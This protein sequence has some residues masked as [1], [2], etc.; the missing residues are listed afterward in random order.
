MKRIPLSVMMCILPAAVLGFW[1][2]VQGAAQQHE[3]GLPGARAAID[4]SRYPTLQAALDALP[5]EGGV[6]RLPA[7]VFEITQPLVVSKE[8]VL[9]QGRSAARS[10]EGQAQLA[11]CAPS[12]HMAAS[13]DRIANGG[14]ERDVRGIH[15][16]A[17]I[18][19]RRIAEAPD[20]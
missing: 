15:A 12:L 16:G 2:S 10:Q 17:H 4:A 13:R 6:V 8:D 9:L 11:A 7:G 19:A 20:G 18:A 3:S 14:G 5:D 1:W